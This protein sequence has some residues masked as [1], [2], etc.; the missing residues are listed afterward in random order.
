MYPPVLSV[1]VDGVVKLVLHVFWGTMGY[2]LHPPFFNVMVHGVVTLVLHVIWGTMGY[3]LHP[4]VLSVVV[5]GV[6]FC[7]RIQLRQA[8]GFCV[9]LGT[10]DH[11]IVAEDFEILY[12]FWHAYPHSHHVLSAT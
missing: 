4:P 6:L 2:C 5:D 3:F 1:V 10:N 11:R 9:V 12:A 7:V 8:V